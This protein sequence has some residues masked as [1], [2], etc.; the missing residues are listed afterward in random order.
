TL[1]ADIGRLQRQAGNVRAGTRQACHKAVTDRVSGQREHDR[2]RRCGLLRGQRWCGSG[3]NDDVDLKPHKL[4][5][6]LGETLAASFR[7]PILDGNGPALEP[8]QLVQTPHERGDPRTLGQCGA[9]SK[10]PDGPQSRGLLRLRRERPRYRRAAEKRYEH[11]TLHLR[12]HSIT[13]SARSRKGSGTLNPIALA[14]LRLTTS[15]NLTGCSTGRSAGLAPCK[16]LCTYTA[17][18]RNRSDKLAP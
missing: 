17:P 7:P 13:S 6:N 15:S 8:T 10:I 12:G 16:I 14:V 18:R 2:D 1:G 5:G 4:G 11:A 9:R 3:G